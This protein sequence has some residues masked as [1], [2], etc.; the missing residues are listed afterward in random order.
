VAAI[1]AQNLPESLADVCEQKPSAADLTLGKHGPRQT[2]VMNPA[3]GGVLNR[4]SIGWDVGFVPD[5]RK[6]THLDAKPVTTPTGI[7]LSGGAASRIPG[8]N[9]IL[10]V[11]TSFSPAVS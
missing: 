6:G 10:S 5:P 2:E 11:S 7:A 9:K 4:S 8:L 1:T 3:T